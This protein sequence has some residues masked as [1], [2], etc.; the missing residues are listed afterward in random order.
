[1]RRAGKKKKTKELD[2]VHPED[3][4]RWKKKGGAR[5]DYKT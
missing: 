2:P 4:R 5:I 3:K 1:M